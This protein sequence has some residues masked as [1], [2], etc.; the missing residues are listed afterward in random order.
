MSKSSEPHGSKP[1][2]GSETTTAATGNQPAP[3]WD[4][5]HSDI[6]TLRTKYSSMR[7][8]TLVVPNGV[9]LGLVERNPGDLGNNWMVLLT[10]GTLRARMLKLLARAMFPRN[11]G[12]KS[13]IRP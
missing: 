9:R 8:N 10:S 2:N 1:S 4:L 6:S 11:Y 3:E 13:R 7:M 12:A 5:L